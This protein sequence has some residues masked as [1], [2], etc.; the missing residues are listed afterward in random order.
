MSNIVRLSA[1]AVL[2]FLPQQTLAQGVDPDAADDPELVR[3]NAVHE[4]VKAQRMIAEEE[5]KLAE[6]QA[7][8]R[9]AKLPQTGTEGLAGDAKVNEGAGYYATILAYETL[10]DAATTIVEGL[11]DVEGTINHLLITTD[12]DVLKA[13][14]LWNVTRLRLED[15]REV[16]ATLKAEYPCEN[17]HRAGGTVPDPEGPCDEDATIDASRA[18]TAAA[19]LDTAGAVLGAADDIASFFKTNR[20]LYDVEVELAD[21]ALL[22]EVAAKAD[23]DNKA[24][25]VHLVGYNV[26]SAGELSELLETLME[27]K[28]DL[29]DRRR[30]LKK[31]LDPDL[32]AL[33]AKKKEESKLEEELEALGEEGSKK[34]REGLQEQITTLNNQM[35]PLVNA[36]ELWL[37]AKSRLDGPL[38]AFD[39]VAGSLLTAPAKDRKTVMEVIAPID[40]LRAKSGTSYCSVCRHC[41][42]GRRVA[43][44]E[45]PALGGSHP[46]SRRQRCRLR[47]SRIRWDVPGLGNDPEHR[48]QVVQGRGRNPAAR[49]I[50]RASPRLVAGIGSE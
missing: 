33:A 14:G 15:F 39:A 31:E 1:I 42:P 11:A 46:L 24:A 29:A 32:K 27:D 36:Q 30:R 35:A 28:R 34:E 40:V 12:R 7:A 25:S 45:T 4:R 41:E 38:A 48:S 10:T 22:A 43:H 5:K 50:K 16:F 44:D 21:D 20:D 23:K 2:V 6:A 18:E 49:R 19:V 8:A 9:R 3:L 13:S 26:A 47:V 17:P 37:E